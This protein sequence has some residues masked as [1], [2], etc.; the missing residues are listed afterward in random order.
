MHPVTSR[1]DYCLKS[2][3]V[4]ATIFSVPLHIQAGMRTAEYESRQGK[5]AE[6]LLWLHDIEARDQNNC[7]DYKE[8]D[9]CEH[10]HGEP[11]VAA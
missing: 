9:A 7:D 3:I 8:R 4:V 5:R 6:L 1:A 2:V 10:V 11:P